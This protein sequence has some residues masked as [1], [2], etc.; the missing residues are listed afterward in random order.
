MYLFIYLKNKNA[1]YLKRNS[2]NKNSDKNRYIIIE[3][4]LLLKNTHF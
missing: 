4:V 1:L 3:K 2:K